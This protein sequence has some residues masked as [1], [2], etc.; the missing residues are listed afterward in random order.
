MRCMPANDEGEKFKENTASL[1][2]IV[3][4]AM[5]RL[6]PA[7]TF[8]VANVPFWYEIGP[9]AFIINCSDEWRL[10][11]FKTFYACTVVGVNVSDMHYSMS[12][13]LFSLQNLS[14]TLFQLHKLRNKST[15]HNVISNLIDNIYPRQLCDVGTELARRHLKVGLVTR[16][17]NHSAPMRSCL[18]L[19]PTTI[20]RVMTIPKWL[21]RWYQKK[22]AARS[23]Y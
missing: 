23:V 13:I 16:R 2:N 6:Q 5:L 22:A 1:E 3:G 8:P 7:A 17:R 15:P 18:F 14:N 21:P 19:L 20:M 10:I 9:N 12:D 11:Q 4:H